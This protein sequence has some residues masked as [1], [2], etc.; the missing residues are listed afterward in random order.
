MKHR[1][2]KDVSN[3]LGAE[4]DELKGKYDSVAKI[5]RKERNTTLIEMNRA[6]K[7][8]TA[9]NDEKLKVNN[10]IQKK[11]F[12]PL[13]LTQMIFFKDFYSYENGG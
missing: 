7:H 2:I 11:S 13:L 6:V 10:K 3:D 9:Y 1:H 8:V 4:L 12:P 5:D